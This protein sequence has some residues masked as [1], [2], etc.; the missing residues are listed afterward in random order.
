MTLYASLAADLMTLRDG[1]DLSQDQSARRLQCV[2]QR[3]RCSPADDGKMLLLT[4]SISCLEDYKIT[5]GWS[6][7]E[8]V[9]A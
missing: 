1:S 9:N 6:I 8:W 2:E 7:L 4:A 5:S 3:H